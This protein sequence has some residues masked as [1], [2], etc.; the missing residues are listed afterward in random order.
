M[1]DGG[2]RGCLSLL[3]GINGTESRAIA[4]RRLRLSGQTA[5][6]RTAGGEVAHLHRDASK[7]SPQY[8]WVTRRGA[9]ARAPSTHAWSS[10][11]AARLCA[12]SASDDGTAVAA[13]GCEPYVAH[14]TVITPRASRTDDAIRQPFATR[15][16]G[17]SSGARR[18]ATPGALASPRRGRGEA[19]KLRHLRRQ[20]AML[21]TIWSTPR[22][23]V[24]TGRGPGCRN[25]RSA[26]MLTV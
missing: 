17:P 18:N 15:R 12:G 22:G 24:R 10:T 2:G 21:L 19:V 1:A 25:D 20:C 4:P 8:E 6:R 23:R 13:C 14:R 5:Q 11:E 16:H 9:P 7:R 26:S 3:I